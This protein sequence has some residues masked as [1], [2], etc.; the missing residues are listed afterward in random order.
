MA[1]LSDVIECLIKQMLEDNN[2]TTIISRSS[3]A[4]QVNCVPSQITYV[5]SRYF[6]KNKFISRPST[7]LHGKDSLI[8]PDQNLLA[9]YGF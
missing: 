9:F 2:G 6:L 5:L 1:R 8:L 7:E 4:E 3:L